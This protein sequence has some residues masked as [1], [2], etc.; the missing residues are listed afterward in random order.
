VTQATGTA[1]RE[2]A[3]AMARSLP[4]GATLGADTGYD[5]AGFVADLRDLGVT[6]HVAQHTTQRR[7]AIDGR[8]TRHPGYR[9]S[10]RKR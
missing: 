1:E 8:T 3:L 5:T 9:V 7:S 4:R 10:Q 6:P 2:A